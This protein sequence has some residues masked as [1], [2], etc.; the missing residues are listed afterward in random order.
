MYPQIAGGVPIQSFLPPSSSAGYYTGLGLPCWCCTTTKQMADMGAF[1]SSSLSPALTN[2]VQTNTLV[3]L[4]IY[5]DKP[6]TVRFSLEFFFCFMAFSFSVFLATQVWGVIGT[7]HL[8]WL[9]RKNLH[10]PI[11][12]LK[13]KQFQ[14][15]CRK[16]THPNLTDP[17]QSKFRNSTSIYQLQVYWGFLYNS[18]R[19]F[20][21]WFNG[22]STHDS[23]LMP[24]PVH[25]YIMSCKWI[26]C[27]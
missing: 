19:D 27:R 14:L 11:L 21:V 13:Q 22:I 7:L 8:P 5:C 12:Q 25:T 9:P 26:V 20:I 15:P 16:E 4:L 10:N 18:R 23:Y 2:T 6:Q 1:F 3:I 24:H 17:T